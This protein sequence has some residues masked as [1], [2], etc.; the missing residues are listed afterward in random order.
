[1]NKNCL[2]NEQAAA[3]FLFNAIS[4]MYQRVYGTTDTYVR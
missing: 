2:P 3:I 1:M 4:Y